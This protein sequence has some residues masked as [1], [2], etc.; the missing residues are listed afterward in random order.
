MGE[1]LVNVAEAKYE[2]GEF[3]QAVA[4]ATINKLRARGAVAPLQLSAIPDDPQRDAA[5]MP[6]LWEIRRERAIELM[7][8]GF[9]FDDLRRWKKMDYAMAQKLGRWIKKGTDVAA[10]AKIPILNNATEGYIAYEGVPR[11][12]AGT[13]IPVCHPLQ[14][15]G[16]QSQ[17]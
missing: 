16:T 6:A 3:N 7:G 2:L 17:T 4:D 1:V 5:I 12:M 9:R 10:D 11:N 14:S 15:A 13:S 8:E